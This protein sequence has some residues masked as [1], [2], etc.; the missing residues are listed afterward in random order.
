MSTIELKE[1]AGVFQAHFDQANEQAGTA[2]AWLSTLRQRSFDRFNEL[3]Y[4]T[5]KDEEWRFT[6]VAPIAKTPFAAPIAGEANVSPDQL[7]PFVFDGT[8]A[9]LVF[10]NGLYCAELSSIGTL[11]KGVRV[12]PLSE[13]LAN[14]PS[15]VQAHLAQH[16]DGKDQ[17]FAALNAALMQDGA[18]VILPQ[19]AV[20][21]QPIHLVFAATYAAEPFAVHPRN[22]IVMGANSQATVVES[23]AG[24]DGGTYLTNTV[25][26]IVAGESA[27]LD[28]YKVVRESDA[29]FHMSALQISQDKSS[30]VTSHVISLGGELVRNDM[31]TTLDAE[32][33]ECTLNGLSM[34]SG[35]RLVDNHLIVDHAKPRC[36]SWEYFKSVLDDKGRSIFSG[37]INVRADAQKTDAKQTNMSLLMSKDAQVESK[38]QLEIFADDVKCTHGATIGQID[39]EAIFYLRSRGICETAAR[40]LLVYAFA[41]ENVDKVRVAPLKATLDELLFARLPGGE[42]LREVL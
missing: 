22:L 26:E 3:G 17:A 11:P 7:A 29:A 2:P 10:V 35:E 28:H 31:H 14:E 5:T 32:G 16:A 19:G 1:A 38:P 6:N 15:L 8:A 4:P 13:A 23:F 37:R 18:V 24:L 34:L 40:S 9:S 42:L 39:E 30:N 41:R 12:L 36:R 25:M 27:V 20:I 33:C 21:E